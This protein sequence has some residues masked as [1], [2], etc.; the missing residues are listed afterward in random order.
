[1]RSFGF[2]FL[3]ALLILGLWSATG[4]MPA[5]GEM[6]ADEYK[7]YKERKE[8]REEQKKQEEEEAKKAAEEAQQAEEE[9]EKD[10]DAEE[11]SG[12]PP[13]GQGVGAG[14]QRGGPPRTGGEGGNEPPARATPEPASKG[15]LVFYT[16]P[17]CQYMTD[18]TGTCP[19]C[20]IP[21]LSPEELAKQAPPA[22]AAK[23]SGKGSGSGRR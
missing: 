1:M 9:E 2:G 6:S 14:S 22:P 8:K 15:P 5:A 10:P 12:K 19:T 7:A 4:P 21:M 3:A 18:S 17:K 23:G 16:C 13:R 20:K 11:G